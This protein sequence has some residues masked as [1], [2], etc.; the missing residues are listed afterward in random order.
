FR[1]DGQFVLTGSY[2]RSA[3]LWEV[4][5]GPQVS[6]LRNEGRIARQATG[7]EPT[8]SMGTND[9]RFSG[10]ITVAIFSPDRRS[11]LPGGWSGTARLWDTASGKPIGKPLQ[12]ADPITAAAFH[13]DGKTVVI[14]SGK[15]QFPTGKTEF[16]DDE[17][18]RRGEARVW[19]VAA[20]V[21]S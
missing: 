16:R 19:D 20:G 11:V 5:A 8:T 18:I 12:H 10:M 1:P 2:D 7:F 17:V 9:L 6:V 15:T 13:P 21:P 14:A 4:A 3:R